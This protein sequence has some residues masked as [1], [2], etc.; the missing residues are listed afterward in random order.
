MSGVRQRRALLRSLAAARQLRR[1]L[2]R[3]ARE[4]P[5]GYEKNRAF[6]ALAKGLTPSER[7]R[8]HARI[9]RETCAA[10]DAPVRR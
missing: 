8:L 2:I 6:E 1:A 4:L 9:Y 3:A 10:C 5:Q 7:A